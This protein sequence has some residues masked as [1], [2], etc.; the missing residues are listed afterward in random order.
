MKSCVNKTA[1]VYTF[2]LRFLHNLRKQAVNQIHLCV[3]PCLCW[4][5]WIWSIY[6]STWPFSA[7]CSARLSWCGEWRQ[8]GIH[9]HQWILLDSL[10]F[11]IYGARTVSKWI[12][13][14]WRIHKCIWDLHDGIN[15]SL[16]KNIFQ[17]TQKYFFFYTNL[18]EIHTQI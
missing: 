18:R 17:C 4:S 5:I 6:C 14:H 16:H 1:E 15:D 2:M 8:S 11:I 13:A 3:L 9:F 12:N 7:C 10:I